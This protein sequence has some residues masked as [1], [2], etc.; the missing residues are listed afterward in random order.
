MCRFMAYMGHPM[1]LAH[2]VL[3]P[4]RSIIKQSYN[5][6]ER[7]NHPEL[8]GPLCH[9]NI[10]A[11]GFGIGWYTESNTYDSDDTPCIFTSISPAWSQLN[12]QF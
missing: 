8:P 7:L 6:K 1:L 12:T 11:D 2:L 10:N 3:W 4:D 5:S 9:G